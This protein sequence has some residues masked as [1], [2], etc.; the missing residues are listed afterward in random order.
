MEYIALY[1]KY[2]PKSFDEVFGQKYVVDILKKSIV[3]NKIFHAYLFS[4]PRGTGKTTMA[5]LFAKLINCEN[6][7]GYL[8]CNECNSCKLI[9]EKVDADIIEIDAASN[10][11]VDEIRNVCDKVSLLPGVSKYKVYI[12][13]EVHMLSISAF[14]ALLKTL[15][16]PPKHVVFILATTEMHKIPETIISRCQCFNFE[17]LSDDDVVNCLKYISQNEGFNISDEV[18]PMI[19]SYCGGCMRDSIGLLEKLSFCTGTVTEEV[20]NDVVGLVAAD[21]LSSFIDFIISKDICSVLNLIEGLQKSGKNL[22]NFLIQAMNYVKKLLIDDNS[23]YDK[24]V[25]ID[26]FSGFNDIFL[27]MKV[28]GSGFLTFQVGVLKIINSL[29]TKNDVTVSPD[30]DSDKVFSSVENMESKT[31]STEI[32]FNADTDDSKNVVVDFSDVIN[33]AFALADKSLKNDVISRWRGFYDYVHNK[34]FSSIVSFLLDAE[35]QV[36]G[37]K[38]IILSSGY[39]SVV[40][41]AVKNI[42]KVELLF[43]LVMGKFYNIAFILDSEWEAYKNKYI[44]DIKNG[45][46]YKYR[47]HFSSNDDIIDSDDVKSDIVSSAKNIFGDDIVEIK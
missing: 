10:N 15:E 9:N 22:N 31:F 44:S 21:C 20:F 13:D 30:L 8:A 14:N 40:D 17:R 33:N 29:I 47:E 18:F 36:V 32:N 38:D 39:D 27:N 2:R 37:E 41:S 1:R 26:I 35:V 34:E 16:E 11:G 12:I 45:K 5:K 4:G 7:N 3:N 6:L 43:N 46:K 25:L 42:A 19:S 28:A 23:V 24:G